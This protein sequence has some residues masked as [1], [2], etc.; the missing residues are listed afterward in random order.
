M[1]T[2]LHKYNHRRRRELNPDNRPRLTDLEEGQTG[3]ILEIAGGKHSSKRLADLGLA[4]GVEITITTT[5]FFSGP[6][7]ICV[8]GSKLVI[9]RGLASRILIEPK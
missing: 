1:F 3:I 9:G 6:I 5:S 8:C 4:P 2:H 7:Q